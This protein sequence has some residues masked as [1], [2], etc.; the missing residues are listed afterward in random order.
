MSSAEISAMVRL[1]KAA[2]Q[3]AAGAGAHLPEVS[4]PCLGSTLKG[5][6]KG[7]SGRETRGFQDISRNVIALKQCEPLLTVCKKQLYRLDNCFPTSLSP[8]LSLMQ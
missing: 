3:L 2:A 6:H 8:L 7:Q 1:S 5:Q 4:L